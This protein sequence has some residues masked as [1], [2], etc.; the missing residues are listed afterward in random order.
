M[1]EAC[2]IRDSN[3]ISLI[4][5]CLSSLSWQ[6]TLAKTKGNSVSESEG[7][8]TNT[9]QGWY[10][11]IKMK[12]SSFIRRQSLTSINLCGRADVCNT[13]EYKF[14]TGS[15][16]QSS[17]AYALFRY[18]GVR[19]LSQWQL[20]FSLS[21]YVNRTKLTAGCM[22]DCLLWRGLSVQLMDSVEW[23]TKFLL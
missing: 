16:K 9:F 12:Y 15:S 18:K 11:Y 23:A 14:F 22:K 8:V 19:V 3:C 10:K 7:N 5:A 13:E 1:R 17:H 21:F 2:I 4:N 20:L 6:L